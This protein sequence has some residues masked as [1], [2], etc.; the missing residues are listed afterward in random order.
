MVIALSR[1][2]DFKTSIY[3]RDKE[4]YH[5]K[6]S[7]YQEDI[8]NTNTYEHDN[9]ATKCMKQKSTEVKGEINSSRITIRDFNNPLITSRN[10]RQR[11]AR[12][13]RLQHYII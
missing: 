11:S 8:I 12:K 4:E 3:V 7:I 5:I 9:R 6:G 10:T 13:T 1:K 2:I